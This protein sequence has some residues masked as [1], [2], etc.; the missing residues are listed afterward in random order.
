MKNLIIYIAI[1]L[2]VV[3]S[4]SPARA[5]FAARE[6]VELQRLIG[7]LEYLIRETQKIEQRAHQGSVSFNY[8]ALV[9]DLIK[10]RNLVIEHIR[11]ANAQPNTIPPAS[12]FTSPVRNSYLVRH[13]KKQ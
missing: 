11:I 9:E 7:E 3:L 1:A 6:G 13:N 8:R 5:D 12:D 4:S 10:M 2:L